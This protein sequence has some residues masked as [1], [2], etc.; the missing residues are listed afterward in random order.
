MIRQSR[1]LPQQDV[2]GRKDGH[3]IGGGNILSQVYE[4]QKVSNI[5]QS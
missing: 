5:R 2:S 3:S 1:V 4:K